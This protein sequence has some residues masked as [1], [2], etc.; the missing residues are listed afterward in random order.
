M[1]YDPDPT[2]WNVTYEPQQG[3]KQK[4]KKCIN[5]INTL[6]SPSSRSS[7]EKSI[8]GDTED[9]SEDDELEEELE[10]LNEGVKG[11]VCFLKFKK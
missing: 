7:S 6:T 8:A 11:G 1:S 9:E 4:P 10:E 3:N 5:P 2:K